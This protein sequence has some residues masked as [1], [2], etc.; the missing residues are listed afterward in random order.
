MFGVI[1]DYKKDLHLFSGVYA[2]LIKA[3]SIGKEAF[4]LLEIVSK[5]GLYKKWL[6]IWMETRMFY[7]E[8]ANNMRF[9]KTHWDHRT[10]FFFLKKKKQQQTNRKKRR[11]LWPF[12]ERPLSLQTA[13][14][15]HCDSYIVSDLKWP[16]IDVVIKIK[17]DVFHFPECSRLRYPHVRKSKTAA[18]RIVFHVNLRF[19]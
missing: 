11:M 5:A 13:F 4:F 8:T 10:N 1:H 16:Q 12:G 6:E 3:I 15:S 19:W 17:A 2:T 9:A 7:Q 18:R 14:T